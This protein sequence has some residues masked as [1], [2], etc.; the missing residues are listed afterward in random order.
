VWRR[1][2]RRRIAQRT[3]SVTAI[4]SGPAH[5]IRKAASE[6]NGGLVKLRFSTVGA[7]ERNPKSKPRLVWTICESA[8]SNLVQAVATTASTVVQT[9][10]VA[11]E[12]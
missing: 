3:P 1:D 7:M 6:A 2:F 12:N 10:S 11:S 5:A 4:D 9:S 8:T